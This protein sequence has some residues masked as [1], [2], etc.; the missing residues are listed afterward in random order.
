MQLKLQKTMQ[1]E[2]PFVENGKVV[3]GLATAHDQK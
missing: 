3:L 1:Q 2:K